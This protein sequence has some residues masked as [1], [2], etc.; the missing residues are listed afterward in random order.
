MSPAV[1]RKKG[2][3]TAS[4]SSSRVRSGRNEHGEQN[5][6]IGWK[7]TFRYLPCVFFVCLEI[8]HL[9]MVGKLPPP[10]LP[11]L[12]VQFRK[13]ILLVQD[14]T[15]KPFKE[16]IL[17]R[18]LWVEVI[19]QYYH[20]WH[21]EHYS[22]K[23]RRTSTEFGLNWL[24]IFL[25]NLK[26]ISTLVASLCVHHDCCDVL[27]HSFLFVSNSVV[28]LFDYESCKVLMM[29]VAKFW[30]WQTSWWTAAQ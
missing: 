25:A 21:V 1:W 10:L 5:N 3:S 2:N 17:Q 23:W 22:G 15:N 18:C 24:I 26:N 19:F 30:W 6:E 14:V 27:V 4:V 28:D 7:S 8:I 29:T 9:P 12:L 11:L 20:S 13:L 16:T